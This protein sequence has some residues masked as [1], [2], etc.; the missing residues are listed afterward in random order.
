MSWPPNV[1]ILEFTRSKRYLQDLCIHKATSWWANLCKV[2]T[3]HNFC[4]CCC[5]FSFF[6]YCSNFKT[7][8]CQTQIKVFTLFWVLQFWCS[9]F[10]R[11]HFRPHNSPSLF[12]SLIKTFTLTY[13]D[14]HWSQI[15]SLSQYHSFKWILLVFFSYFM[16][17][18][19][20]WKLGVTVYV[21]HWFGDHSWSRVVCWLVR[22]V[23]FTCQSKLRLCTFK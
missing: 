7:L 14:H 23:L 2:Q 10:F 17:C 1:V 6:A 4:C 9:G 18:S 15:I 21:K 20:G 16:N 12:Y 22:L 8:T 19:C 5:C 13:H 3:R 11:L